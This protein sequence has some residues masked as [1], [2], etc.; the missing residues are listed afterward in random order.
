MRREL[1]NRIRFLMEDIVPPVVRDSKAF[2]WLM[3]R[4]YGPLVYRLA[5]FRQ[6]SHATSAEAYEALYRNMPRVHDDTDN[7]RAVLKRIAELVVPGTIC[8]VGCGTGHTVGWLSRQ[9]RLAG[10]SFTGVDFLI[11]DGMR[12]AHP[13][14]T[15]VPSVIET[16]PFEDKQFDTVICTHTLEH[17][18]DVRKA[19]AELR[20]VCRRRLILVV[21][22]EREGLYTFNAHLH[23]FPYLHSFLRILL[24]LPKQHGGEV[25]GRDL[26]YWEDFD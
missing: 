19:I 24:P 21:P 22:R 7:S 17:I 10:S 14:V 2:A 3:A 13:Q 15:F 11:D 9:E 1:T 6:Q 5:E 12:A 23:F 16:L 25:I 20:R 18:L 26:L 8:D 4:A